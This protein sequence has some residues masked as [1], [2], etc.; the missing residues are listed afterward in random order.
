[1]FQTKVQLSCLVFTKI[2]P[3]LLAGRTE[4]RG[5]DGTMLGLYKRPRLQHGR[6]ILALEELESV[7]EALN[8]RLP[9][10]YALLVLLPCVDA[11]WLEFVVVPQK[12][13]ICDKVNPIARN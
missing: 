2:C 10:R 7:L 8:L 3:A 12:G 5:R 13:V 11:C 4:S 1:M 6:E 9:A